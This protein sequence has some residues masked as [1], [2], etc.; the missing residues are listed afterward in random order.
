MAEVTCN[1]GLSIVLGGAGAVGSAIVAE[2][3]NQ[4]AQVLVLDRTA[5]SDPAVPFLRVDIS[6]QNSVDQVF[7]QIDAQASPIGQLFVASGYLDPG[8]MLDIGTDALSRHYEINVIGAF[9]V[10]Q[11]TATR[12][13]TAGGGR[14]VCIGSI[15]GQIG[16]PERGAYAM[17]K[18]ALCAMVRALAVEL[19][20]FAIR[21]NVLAPGAVQHGMAPQPQTRDAWQAASPAHRVAT[22][23]EVARFAVFLAA[24]A[25]SFLSGQTIALDGG[26]SNLRPM[27]GALQQQA[28]SG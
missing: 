21:V 16:V 14:I 11:A 28:I 6:D 22:L 10:L 1:L 2:L 17:S 18:A 13:K 5:P 23:A 8:A 15:H 12:M 19:A 27:P 26:A 24:P 4:G 25:A 3:E 7:A 9:R 20:P